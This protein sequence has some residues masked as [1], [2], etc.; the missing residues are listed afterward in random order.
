MFGDSGY[1][2]GCAFRF[3][4]KLSQQNK[5]NRIR[6]LTSVLKGTSRNLKLCDPVQSI[7]PQL[8]SLSAT[9]VARDTSQGP[10]LSATP[11]VCLHDVPTILRAGGLKP[12]TP[13]TLTADLTDE[14]GKQVSGLCS[15]T[16]MMH[17]NVLFVLGVLSMFR[18]FVYNCGW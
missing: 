2:L 7:I 14:N 6:V 13:V 17:D 10:W 5:M 18:T 9:P 12:N 1:L 3:K 8:R 16:E 11:R 4:E 15:V